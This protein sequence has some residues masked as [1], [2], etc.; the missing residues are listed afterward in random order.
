MWRQSKWLIVCM[1]LALFA[2]NTNVEVLNPELKVSPTEDITFI[3]NTDGLK[4]ET[5]NSLFVLQILRMDSENGMVLATMDSGKIWVLSF[6]NTSY[7]NM[8]ILSG[9]MPNQTYIKDT[10]LSLTILNAGFAEYGT[11]RCR[12]YYE[13]NG[14][15]NDT[16]LKWE[17]DIK[18]IPGKRTPQALGFEL[19]VGRGLDFTCSWD[20]FRNSQN[21]H[22]KM[23]VISTEDNKELIVASSNQNE[24][25]CLP[26]SV[27]TP[28]LH[29][30]TVL[31]IHSHLSNVTCADIT[32]Y[33]CRVTQ[34]QK[35][36]VSQTVTPQIHGCKSSEIHGCKPEIKYSDV[37]AWIHAVDIII[38]SLIAI[39]IAGI[40]IMVYNKRCSTNSCL[41]SPQLTDDSRGHLL[42]QRPPETTV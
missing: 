19:T 3:C 35:T 36:M 32:P 20:T 16:W 15:K 33:L 40:S 22:V 28:L 38:G 18:F 17:R 11:Y 41:H 26:G 5:V 29:V 25:K 27:C 21:H 42:V 10:R 9:Y 23:S 14:I 39:I 34:D 6:M 37:P 8:Y 30:G 4:P 1:L 31:V 2:E 24:T 7:P 12:L 13:R